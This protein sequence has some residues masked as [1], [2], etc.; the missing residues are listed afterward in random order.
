MK[1]LIVTV[2]GSPQP[3]VTSIG[4]M[5]PLEIHFICSQESEG[6]VADILKDASAEEMLHEITIIAALDD[7]NECYDASFKLI[8]KLRES[9]PS[10]E[11]I[12]DYT[13]GTKSMAA[14]LAAAALDMPGTKLAVVTGDRHDLLKVTD[15][16]QSLRT[17]QAGKV[18]IQR[19]RQRIISLFGNFDYPAAIDRLEE[20]LEFP[21]VPAED[22]AELQRW[23][24][25]AKVLDAWDRFDHAAAWKILHHYKKYYVSLTMFL[26]AV[27]WS[28]KNLDTEFASHQMEDVGERPKGHGYEIIEDLLL[29]AERRA[30]HKRY[31][32]AVARLYR[33]TELLVQT[34][35]KLQYGIDTGNVSPELLPEHLRQDY[36]N[37]AGYKGK[38]TLSLVMSFELLAKMADGGD[39]LGVLYKKKYRTKLREFLSVRNYSLMAHGFIPITAENYR[40]E[41]S[42]F[43]GL[44]DDACKALNL[45]RYVTRA[46]FPT[47]P[48][49]HE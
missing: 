5:N 24:S 31:D 13:G 2:G 4:K 40:A 34:R 17:T 26:E 8:G 44:L 35:L 47:K 16:T 11:I 28:R 19:A 9:N 23:L 49:G 6:Q 36:Q 7:F 21:D 3:I 1:I 33:A 45:K 38:I 10:A 48:Q 29:N 43:T 15:G 32:D 22:K 14:G 25:L 30:T 12:A 27:I 39:P 46:Q 37:L 18:Y 42:F 20:M 41:H